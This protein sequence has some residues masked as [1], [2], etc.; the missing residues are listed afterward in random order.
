ML[1]FSFSF[2]FQFF[3][4]VLPKEGSYDEYIARIKRDLPPHER[5][6]HVYKENSIIYRCN[7][8]AT[9]DSSCL[10]AECF[11]NGNHEVV[12]DGAI[13][14]RV[15]HSNVTTAVAVGAATAETLSRGVAKAGAQS[16]DMRST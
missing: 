7:D 1:L 13:Q 12:T 4:R 3:R 11:E 14:Y 9:G 5:C 15:I 10:C 8:C 16:I 6:H 2:T